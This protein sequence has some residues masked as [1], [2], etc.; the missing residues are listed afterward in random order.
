M[1]R[2]DR[3]EPETGFQSMKI[4]ARRAR[5]SSLTRKL[6]RE[7]TKLSL[8]PIVISALHAGHL[9]LVEEAARQMC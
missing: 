4:I 5:M 2:I 1:R 3:K 7:K 8:A 6:R 9:S